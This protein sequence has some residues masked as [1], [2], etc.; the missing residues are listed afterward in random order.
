MLHVFSTLM[1]IFF[2]YPVV[3]LCLMFKINYLVPW[4]YM[5]NTVNRLFSF[6]YQHLFVFHNLIFELS[7]FLN[8]KNRVKKEYLN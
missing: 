6:F 2:I 5:Y 7:Q 1:I 8:K 3:M 4:Y